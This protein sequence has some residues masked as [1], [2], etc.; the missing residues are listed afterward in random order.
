MTDELYFAKKGLEDVIYAPTTISKV[1]PDKKLLLYRG[2]A[3]HEL[4]A[5]CAFE[6]VAHLVLL[7]ELPNKLQLSSFQEEERRNRG[8]SAGALEVLKLIPQ[9]AHPMDSLR[10]AVSFLGTEKEFAEEESPEVSLEK[11][12]L[13]LAKIPTLVAFDYRVRNK[14]RIIPPDPALGFA[15]NFFYMCFGSVPDAE[16]VKALDASLTLYAEH[17]FNAS[18]FTARV[19][20]SSLSD[21]CSGVVAGI[22]SLKGPLHGGA[23]EAVMH[24]LKEIGEP[25]RVESWLD[26]QLLRKRKIMGFGHRLYR[27]GDSRVPT[28]K[29]YRDV[30]VRHTNGEKWLEISNRLEALMLSKKG[31]HP[32]LD[33]PAGPAYFMMGFEIPMFTPI[34]VMARITGWAAHIMEQLADNRLVRPRSKY[35]G[36]PEREV[37]AIDQR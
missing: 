15:E 27:L 25:E 23:N 33:F 18:T 12:M 29:Q 24:V 17:G 7:G 8:I 20:V 34:F 35:E 11:A 28:M 37:T 22:S 14:F 1:I 21:L 10:T 5:K 31:I 13:L 32:N 30:M 2:Y 16:V 26:E 3:V 19:A 9:G 6:E 4:A 36:P